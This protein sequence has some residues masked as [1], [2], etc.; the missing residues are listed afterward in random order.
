MKKQPL[1]CKYAWGHLDFLQGQYAPC[2]RFKVYKQPIG[3]IS[4]R[5]PSEIINSQEMKEVRKS[6]QE[7]VFPPG[8]F[9]CQYK[10][11]T[12]LK[13]YRKRA[14]E[15][16]HFDSDNNIDYN[17][18]EIKKIYDLE[19]KFS[20][21]CNFLCRHCNSESN[22]LFEVIGKKN[23]DI[24]KALLDQDFDH[25][26]IAES[27]IIDIPDNVIDD[28]IKNVIPTVENIFFSGGEPLY[29]LKHYKFLERLINDPNI[30]TKK[31]DIG[32]NTNLSMI[33]FKGYKLSELWNHFKSVHVTV[34]LDG[35]RSLFNYFRERGDYETIIKNIYELSET[36]P[37]LNSFLFVCTS[38]AYHAFYADQIFSDLCKLSFDIKSKYKKQVE[39]RPTFVH[40]P[41][42]DMVDLDRETKNFIIE[43]LKKTLPDS[44][45]SYNFSISEIIK[46]LS[47]EVRNPNSDFKKIV[48]LQDKLYNKDPFVMAPR[49]A[50]YVYNNKLTWE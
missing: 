39:V 50:E 2:F 24:H 22:S 37:N 31:I 20:R 38:S 40:T 33:S 49:V 35:T 7:G 14:E 4:E 42:L 17:N 46:H 30:D 29:S 27:P 25:L 47:N 44:D 43:N 1:H 45:P 32:Y 19:L 3:K 23:P 41:G 36:V 16:N 9:D 21:N 26:G 5:L 13:S 6:L 8:C 10:E 12:G 48:K 11:S 28:L 18:V 34:S 15:R